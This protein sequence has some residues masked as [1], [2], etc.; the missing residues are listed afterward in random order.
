MI[1][2]TDAQ[3]KEGAAIAKR[4]GVKSLFINTKGEFFTEENRALFSEG[5]KAENT[6]KLSFTEAEAVA[7]KVEAK[8]AAA[9]KEKT[10]VVETAPK[11][12]KEKTNAKPADVKE[13]ADAKPAE[14]EADA[15][16]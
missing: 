7:S 14:A 1:K 9:V 4:L 12:V 3:K 10:A 15:A 5:G 11:T 2:V 16:K 13:K 6:D 8:P